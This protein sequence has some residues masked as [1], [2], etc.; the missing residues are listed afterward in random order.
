MGIMAYEILNGCKYVSEFFCFC[1][2][3]SLTKPDTVVVE[4]C[5]S[6]INILRMDEE[7]LLEEAK[8]INFEKIQ[9]AIK[10]VSCISIDTSNCEMYGLCR[11]NTCMFIIV[12]RM[13]SECL[14]KFYKRTELAFEN[15][16]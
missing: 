8:N 5:S 13:Q 2:T 6:R 4:L 10:Q 7:T 3:I 12:R 14:V 15:K 9:Q 16:M 11:M 1:Q